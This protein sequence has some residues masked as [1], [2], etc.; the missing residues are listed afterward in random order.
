MKELTIGELRRALTHGQAEQT[1]PE[2]LA[3][4]DGHDEAARLNERQQLGWLEFLR[5]R[6]V[7]RTEATEKAM[8]RVD[9]EQRRSGRPWPTEESR[10]K[11]RRAAGLEAQDSFDLA[12]PKLDFQEWLDAGSPGRYQAETA[13][14]RAKGFIRREEMRV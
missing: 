5:S 12:E 7:R 3:A 1:I 13:I 10:P 8:A 11:A 4:I 6:E 9:D 14:D 2:A